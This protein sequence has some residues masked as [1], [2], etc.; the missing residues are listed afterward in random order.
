M[1]TEPTKTPIGEAMLADLETLGDLPSPSPVVAQLT[2]MLWRD[3]VAL[4]E[5]ESLVSRD[6]VIAGRL[7]SA[8][9]AAAYAGY[10]PVASLRGALLRLGI[11]RVRRLAL[12]ISVC[13]A[14]PGLK[15]PSPRFWLHSLAV[16]QV[17][18]VLAREAAIGVEPEAALLGGLVHD[19][20]VLV[21]SSHYPDRARAAFARA[22]LE[23]R[24][25]VEIERELSGIDHAE[26]GGALTRHWALPARVT[27]AVRFHH[28]PAAAPA[29]QR[30][31]A[32]VI[33][34]ADAA[35]G[36]VEPDWD[37]GEEQPLA[38]DDPALAM[39]GLELAEVIAIAEARAGDIGQAASIVAAG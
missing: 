26:I 4:S 6:P 19:L 9:N 11:E 7:L 28:A 30:A 22:R 20:G 24:P 23:H 25:V 17:A 34:L 13:N 15:A 14:V 27:A 21:I 18:E 12:V 10:A 5:I 3:D 36:V 38:D 33:R 16:A 1:K 37:L 39:V 2:G 32:A 31:A 35:V 8:A 29:E